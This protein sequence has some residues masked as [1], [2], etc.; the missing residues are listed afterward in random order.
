MARREGPASTESD[1]QA[2]KSGWTM[3]DSN[4][5]D[6]L[7]TLIALHRRLLLALKGQRNP[8]RD[9][10]FAAQLRNAE[11]DVRSRIVSWQ[12]LDEHEAH[13]KLEHLASYILATGTHLDAVEIKAICRSVARFF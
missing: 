8:A 11:R 10:P 12:P 9:N 3:D 2:I 4:V 7:T 6:N 1:N 5:L 13:L